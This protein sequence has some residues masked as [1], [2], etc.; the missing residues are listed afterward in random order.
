MKL[1]ALALAALAFV[2]LAW[3]VVVFFGPFVDVPHPPLVYP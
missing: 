3:C 2:A 1:A